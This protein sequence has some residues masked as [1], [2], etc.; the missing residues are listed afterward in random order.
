[1]Q[2][3]L[4]LY[5]NSK[6]AKVALTSSKTEK[7]EIIHEAALLMEYGD[8]LALMLRGSESKDPIEIRIF[9]KEKSA[10]YVGG[11]LVDV[12]YED[13]GYPLLEVVDFFHKFE[14]REL[15]G[16]LPLSAVVY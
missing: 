5:I 9:A 2:N 11:I 12:D 7:V 6:L 10:Q 13:Y 8:K 15:D 3:Q 1:M 4:H 16:V 14:W